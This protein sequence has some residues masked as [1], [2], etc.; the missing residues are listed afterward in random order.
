M[1]KSPVTGLGNLGL[2][3]G[4]NPAVLVFTLNHSSHP[5]NPRPNPL[6]F[7]S[8]NSAPKQGVGW[9]VKG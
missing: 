7:R 5:S 8:F 4:L 6:L 2:G 1:Y 3:L 9:E